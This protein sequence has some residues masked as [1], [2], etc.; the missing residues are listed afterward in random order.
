MKK[1]LSMLA[2]AAAVSAGCGLNDIFN[3]T[4]GGTGACPSNVTLYRIPTG[5]YTTMSAQ[6]TSD[7]C[8]D[9]VMP[10]DLM[11]NRTVENDTTAG[12]IIVKGATGAELG[13]GPVRC[14]TGTITFGPSTIDDGL[15]RY[16]TTRTS[17]ITVI[18]DST[19]TLNFKDDRSNTMN[20][21]NCPQPATCTVSWT[22]TMKQ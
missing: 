8:K 9:G 17:T 22:A 16:T 2:V 7:T 21:N 12:S 20:V 11:K 15:C 1:F 18:A 5:T 14:N 6:V 19:F 4:D 3:T 10:A 13:R